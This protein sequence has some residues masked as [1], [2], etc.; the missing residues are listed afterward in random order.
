MKVAEQINQLAACNVAG[1]IRHAKGLLSR[2]SVEEAIEE[3][4]KLLEF[5]DP[6]GSTKAEAPSPVMA[7]TEQGVKFDRVCRSQKQNFETLCSAFKAGDVAIMECELVA[8]K[9]RVAVIVAA[10]SI[11][12]S[13]EV[14]QRGK[15]KR[16]V[17]HLKE[18]TFVPFAVMLNGNPYRLLNPPNPDGGFLSQEEAWKE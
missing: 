1:R 18:I 14:E 17:Q 3:L 15:R 8:T 9:E 5:V 4:D 12:Q 16:L 7:L 11:W 6:D 2:G 13:P 10:N